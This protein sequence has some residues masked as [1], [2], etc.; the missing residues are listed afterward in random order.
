[1]FIA[2]FNQVDSDSEVFT[3][4]KHGEMPFIGTVLAGTYT[5][6]II[7]GTMFEREELVANKPYACQN[8]TEDWTNPDTNEVVTQTRVQIIG[9]VSMLDFNALAKQCGKTKDMIVR[10]T[11][12]APA[13]AE[14]TAP[15]FE[16]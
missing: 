12:T 11:S 9:E 15:A 13:T 10:S 4:N 14:T 1:M 3:A 6:T 16:A 5:G 7:D 8:Y 2:K